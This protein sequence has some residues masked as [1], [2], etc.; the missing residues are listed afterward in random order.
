MECEKNTYINSAKNDAIKKS[1]REMNGITNKMII[2]RSK[3][4][5]V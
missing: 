5:L 1:L 3:E 4:I 2:K